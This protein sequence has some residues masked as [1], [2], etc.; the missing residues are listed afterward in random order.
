MELQAANKDINRYNAARFYSIYAAAD[1]S[2]RVKAVEQLM[3]QLKNLAASGFF[4]QLATAR[5]KREMD[6]EWLRNNDR[7]IAFMNSL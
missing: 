5:I 1:E 7:F 4:T 6:F 3:T 2:N